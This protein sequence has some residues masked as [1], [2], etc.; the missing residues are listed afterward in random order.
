MPFM[1]KTPKMFN[2]GYKT[3]DREKAW[4]FAKKFTS[5]SNHQQSLTFRCLSRRIKKCHRL[6]LNHIFFLTED[7]AIKFSCNSTSLGPNGYSPCHLMQLGFRGVEY[8]HSL[9][10]LSLR[11]SD[12]PLVWKQATIID[13]PKAGKPLTPSTSYCSI[14]FLSPA[15]NILERLP[16]S[17]L[18]ECLPSAEHQDG[19]HSELEWRNS[20]F[21]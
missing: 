5:I 10:N 17:E 6:S 1:V 14:P 11:E 18:Q 2:N 3:T 13:L 9:P 21:E 20:L 7:E 19:F 16:L 12:L 8:L 4:A 15:L